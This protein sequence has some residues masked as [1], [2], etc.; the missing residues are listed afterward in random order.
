MENLEI[1]PLE[2]IPR[3]FE[4]L[5]NPKTKDKTLVLTIDGE[6]PDN[7]M[8]FWLKNEN[9]TYEEELYLIAQIEYPDDEGYYE[10]S[11][12]FEG[13]EIS[14]FVLNID[15]LEAHSRGREVEYGNIIKI[16]EFLNKG[17]AIDSE[18]IKSLIGLP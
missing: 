5:I 16:V 10:T 17:L 13:L 6:E 7:T 14:D 11:L 12:E 18:Q 15:N 2:F 8:W 9:L 1:T 3:V 4:I